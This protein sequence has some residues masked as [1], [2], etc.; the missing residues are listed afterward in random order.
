MR[1]I[2]PFLSFTLCLC[3]TPAWAASGPSER[4]LTDPRSVASAVNPNA[5]PVPVE[6]LFFTR[7]AYTPAWSHDGRWI[8]FS[9]NL[10]GRANVYKVASTG[11]WPIQMVQSEERQ[12]F[13]VFSPDDRWIVYQQDFGGGEMW[14]L[15]AIPADGGEPVNVTKT[16]EVSEERPMWSPDGSLLAFTSKLKTSSVRDIAVFDWKTR[17][18][19]TLTADSTND[20]IWQFVAWSPDGKSIYANRINAG[21]TDADVYRIDV[22]SGT[23]ENLTPHEGERMYMGGDVSPDGK[24][25]LISSNEMS[26]YTNVALLEVATRKRRWVTGTEWEASPGTFSP[27]GL[28]FTYTINHDGLLDTYLATRDG[29]SKKITMGEGRTSPSGNP[30][31]FSPDGER[32]L[33]SH[34][35]PQ[36][37]LDLWMLDIAASKTTQLTYSSIATLTPALLPPAHVVHYES[38]DGRTIS[39]ILY[40]PY[41]LARNGSNPAIVLP[42]GGPTAQVSATFARGAA[43]LA[44]HGYIC[45]APNVRGST[46]YGIE[47]QKLNVKD[48][49][50]GDLQDVIHA[51]RWL[52]ETGYVD[53]R[54]IGITGNSYGG[55][56]TLM[57]IGKTPDVWAAAVE[58]FGIINWLTVMEHA[59]PFLRKYNEAL[60]G[61][62]VQDRAIYE[63]SSPIKYLPHAKAPL[64][65]LQGENDIR[66]PKEEA[67][68]V[69]G[70]YEKQGKIV[71]AKFYAQEGHGFAKREN[72]IDVI[73]R[74]LA[75]FDKYLKNKP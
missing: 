19:R 18:R 64:L 70:I 50:G 2:V 14:D 4:Q 59:D 47:F 25:L 5:R 42:H 24:T 33:L 11:G 44:S 68:Q 75:W 61:D 27:D 48:L 10:T 13:T 34:E 53:A 55:F 57:A 7:T 71:E 56:M 43:V 63:N 29:R 28:R 65:V 39:A 30:T 51:V 31:A 58:Q 23:S 8:V 3:L 16:A 73:R 41:N 15:F 32:L 72:Q 45:I 21:Y 52:I 60:L 69:V 36:Q 62:L 38:F 22:A 37:P 1:G 12:F 17:Q 46:G 6:D 40:L 26:G 74:T 54:K 67:D 49:G 9:T 35:S 20:H 66:V